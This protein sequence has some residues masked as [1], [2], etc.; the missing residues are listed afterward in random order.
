MLPMANRECSPTLPSCGG[1]RQLCSSWL[2]PVALA[3]VPTPGCRAGTGCPRGERPECHRSTSSPGVL[4]YLP[5]VGAR[6]SSS[7]ALLPPLGP[8]SALAGS[9][10][11]PGGT[12]SSAATI[13]PLTAPSCTSADT[14]QH[15]VL[16]LC[17]VGTLFFVVVGVFS[18]IF[19]RIS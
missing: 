10:A 18:A 12:A 5:L 17:Q 16:L 14:K 1:T 2:E 4:R 13:H 9:L 8:G 15:T 3:D 19:F 11:G 7:R 6:G